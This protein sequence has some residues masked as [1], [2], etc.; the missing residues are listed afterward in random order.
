[1]PA[2]TPAWRP[3]YGLRPGPAHHIR[4]IGELVEL[5]RRT[6]VRMQISHLGVA[7]RRAW[8]SARAVLDEFGA[9]GADGADV[10]PYPVGVG[11]LQ[12]IFPPW[13]V[14]GLAGGRAG[15]WTRAKIAVL[16]RLQRRLAGLDYGDVQLLGTAVPELA[17]LSG[18]DFGAIAVRLGTSPAGAELEIA[19]RT[20]LAGIVAIH[21][22]SGDAADDAPL[23]ELLGHPRAAVTSNAVLTAAGVPNPAAYGA[24]PRL[25]GRY[26]RDHAVFPLEEAVRRVT[27]LPADR[28]GLRD[29][30]RIAEGYRA[31]LV[32]FD[33]AAVADAG[34]PARPPGPP[35]GI[36]DVLIAGRPAL[37]GGAVAGT[38]GGGLLTRAAPS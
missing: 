37:H 31:D 30:G 38:G 5:A 36:R 34:W 8:P 17:A 20:R 22:F 15:A 24:F 26:A 32:I 1:M 3:V 10:V 14:P 2:R 16:A 11:P 9:D 27:A 13:A 23:R 18:L 7:G 21:A 19:R 4:A 29:V 35:A 28:M 25:I 6:G 12:M 33:P